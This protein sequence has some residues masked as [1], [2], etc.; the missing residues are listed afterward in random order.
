MPA[1]ARPVPALSITNNYLREQQAVNVHFAAILS[2]KRERSEKPLWKDISDKSAEFKFWIGRWELL[3]IKDELLCMKW[4][5][6]AGDTWKVWR[7]QKRTDIGRKPKLL[8]HW[9]GPWLI[10]NKLSDVLFEIKH[11]NKLPSVV[12]HG[13]NLKIY[14]GDKT[15]MLRTEAPVNT[16]EEI[17]LPGLTGY[18]QINGSTK[19]NRDSTHMSELEME[20]MDRE[21][22]T[23][24]SNDL[25]HG[26]SDPPVLPQLMTRKGRVVHKPKKLLD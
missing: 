14:H 5:S 13:D 26:S 20:N 11:S 25:P 17:P 15:I 6:S 3:D 1:K 24:L 4:K 23:E 7:Y 18:Q 21:I 9:S 19:D 10:I 22:Q 8:R 2:L 12:V 16:T